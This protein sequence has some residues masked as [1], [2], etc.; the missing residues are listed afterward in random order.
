M[1]TVDITT[2]L[3][4]TF[5]EH[6][7][8]SEDGLPNPPSGAPLPVGDPSSGV[9]NPAKSDIRGAFT[10]VQTVLQIAVDA[11][12]TAA[13][14]AEEALEATESA[15]AQ[16]LVDI[17]AAES[18]AVGLL[19][20][21]V[22]DAVSAS[23]VPIVSTRNAVQVL[24]IPAGLGAVRTNG[25]SVMGDGGESLF[26]RVA[27]EPAHDGKV[28]SAD[29]FLPN[30]STDGSNGGWWELIGGVVSPEQFGAAN[31]G[32]TADDAAFDRAYAYL[33]QLSDGGTLRLL[34]GGGYN[35]AEEHDI[36][37]YKRLRIEWDTGSRV[38]CSLTGADK[39]L[40][41]ATHPT[42][43]VRGLPME[44]CESKI[45]VHPSLASNEVAALFFEYR[46]ASDLNFLGDCEWVHDRANT[47]VR[48]S[49]CWNCD[50][51]N[52]S[53]WFGGA[54]FLHKA[55]T[56]VTFS[57]IG[58]DTSLY[59]SVPHF[60]AGDVGRSLLLSNGEVTEMFTISGVTN[61]QLAT[62]SRPAHFTFS[63][64]NG[65]WEGVRG[66]MTS[67]SPTLTLSKAALTAA[68]VGRVV[69]VIGARSSLGG[70]KRPLRATIT[71]VAGTSVT[72]DTDASES[73]SDVYVVFSPA[74]EVFGED[75]WNITNDIS[76]QDA[77]IVWFRGT[78]LV[79]DQALNVNLERCKLHAQNFVYDETSSM[80]CAV[81]SNCGGWVTGNF[82]GTCVNNIGRV[83]VTDTQSGFD[84]KGYT[85]IATE[86][87][88]QV[89]HKDNAAA[90][91]LG[92]GN[93]M[94]AN[95]GSDETT[96]AAI[97]S[98]GVGQV[99]HYGFVSTAGIVAN[100]PSRRSKRHVFSEKPIPSSVGRVV[101]ASD[102][103]SAVV[104]AIAVT[105][106]VPGFRG[107]A[108]GGTF[109]APATVGDYQP[110]MQLTAFAYTATWGL[111]PIGG[112]QIAARSP[113]STYVSSEMTFQSSLDGAVATRWGIASNGDLFVG[114]DNAYDIGYG[115]GRVKQIVTANAVIVTS[116]E[117]A[118]QDIEAIPD[119]WLDAW[120]DIEWVRYRLKD[121]VAEKGDDARWH[122]GLL[123]QR[124]R[125]AF[126]AHGID[127]FAIGLLCHDEWPAEPARDAVLGE[128]GKVISPAYPGREAGS[129]FGLRYTECFA[130]EAA[131]SRREHARKDAR[132]AKLAALLPEVI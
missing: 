30:G 44:V 74:V 38:Y 59:S 110:A 69:Y 46:F 107:T 63:F 92:V 127:A 114:A 65:V 58:T 41:R 126:A 35:L 7:R 9:H 26:V 53:F 49:A 80:F 16:A 3:N 97:V 5:R 14:E 119:E 102:T 32:A 60:V 23:N 118:K 129:L 96:R 111:N 50:L 40:F 1:T 51:G 37:P 12:E 31:D 93:I 54:N 86:H 56:G 43:G 78:G 13:D 57:V 120:G 79:V 28:R 85:A 52:A 125:D 81:F 75:S 33:M 108:Y 90:S 95:Q 17:D 98:D 101:A 66:S 10:D 73:V 55:S 88:P 131:W 104:E 4:K 72:L 128:D 62:L 61:G 64:A 71:S 27:S 2:T 39:V 113:T 36:H 122:V 87:Q 117:N 105:G 48:L 34:A 29:R 42:L 124:V 83:Y 116:D 91:V 130:L 99:D 89:F 121:S 15:A 47:V 6:R 112:G 106:F 115:G 70:A 76:W 24:T 100:A 94:L 67:G 25:F 11:A 132:I 21:L 82:E 45:F 18:A 8:Y 84:I 109:S 103:E 123:A 20:G 68:D 22:N 19:E 77:D